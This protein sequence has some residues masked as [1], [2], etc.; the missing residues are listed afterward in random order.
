MFSQE[1]SR[2]EENFSNVAN[3]PILTQTARSLKTRKLLNNN[4]NFVAMVRRQL[5]ILSKSYEFDFAVVLAYLPDE[6]R[7]GE[8][9]YKY[10]LKNKSNSFQTVAFEVSVR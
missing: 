9:G 7:E 10:I 8:E 4:G 2:A 5:E 1:T 3:I 6:R